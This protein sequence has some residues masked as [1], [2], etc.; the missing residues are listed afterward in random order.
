MSPF[1]APLMMKL[2]KTVCY[3]TYTKVLVSC[4]FMFVLCA[5]GEFSVELDLL[6]FTAEEH[7]LRVVATDA[8]GQTASYEYTFTGIPDLML[9]CVYTDNT[10]FCESNNMLTSLSCAFD[11][12]QAI[13]CSF[14]LE[15]RLTGLRLGNHIVTV[16]AT[17]EFTQ[18]DFF[19]LAFEFMLGAINVSIPTTTS[20]IEG[21]PFSPVPFSISGQA[22]SDFSFVVSPL[23]YPQFESRTG[24][25]V[26][27]LFSEVPDRQA[28]LSK[29]N[30]YST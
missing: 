14:P 12:Q 27:S 4:V 18:T 22:L 20:V 19:S 23:T 16:F 17:D 2:L 13:E 8:A 25:S 7:T 21:K 6:E 15:I 28:D 3:T 5:G 29:L 24:L 10:L 26:N 1:L 9:T 30:V 11:G